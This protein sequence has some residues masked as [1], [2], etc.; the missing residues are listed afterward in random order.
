MR[1]G[2]LNARMTRKRAVQLGKPKV[3]RKVTG[4]QL[5][6]LME[7]L[8]SEGRIRSWE[9]QEKEGKKGIMVTR[10]DSL[11]RVHRRPGAWKTLKVLSTSSRA[12][13]VSTE[14][15]WGTGPENGVLVLDT[16]RGRRTSANARKYGVGGRRR[17]R[18]K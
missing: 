14:Q 15:R 3:C 2:R 7:L 1:V 13:Y 11:D 8:C 16:P 18:W 6:A 4:K 9:I 10:V 5:T 12:Q 17:A